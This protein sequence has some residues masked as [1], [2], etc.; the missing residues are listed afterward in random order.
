[1]AAGS[2]RIVTSPATLVDEYADQPINIVLNH[3]ICAKRYRHGTSPAARLVLILVALLPVLANAQYAP[4]ALTAESPNNASSAE[5]ISD[6]LIVLDSDG[7]SHT[8]QHTVATEGATLILQIPGSVIPQEVMFFGPDRDHFAALHKDN[9]SIVSLSSGSAFA[10]YQHQYGSD[11]QQVQPGQYVLSTPS[12]PANIELSGIALNQSSITWVF[13]NEFE[14]VS[15]TVTDFDTGRWVSA[16][17]T[18][19]FHNVDNSSVELSINYRKVAGVLSPESPACSDVNAQTDACANDLD[20]DGVPDYRDI[21]VSALGVVTNTLGCDADH[22]I[23]LHNIKFE[24][25]RTYLDV[26]ARNLLDKVAHAINKSE[27]VF[28]EIGAHTDNV[29][30]AQSNLQLSQKRAEAVRH[31]LM[32]KGVSPNSL[33][34][35]GYG[36]K[37]PVRDNASADGRRANRRTELIII[38]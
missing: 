2:H 5:T 7:R 36:E 1:M 17:N 25:G 27:Y 13:P 31:Y 20:E 21:C 8:V 3:G 9:P 14:I 24:T 4:D 30:A 38:N 37:Y 29:G 23:V 28:Y 15:Y 16:N 11:V 33:R 18:L 6:V 12:V 34:A 22:G 19:T 10:R 26:T 35:I 32:L